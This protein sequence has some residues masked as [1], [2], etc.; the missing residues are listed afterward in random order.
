V[1]RAGP[2]DARAIL[3]CTRELQVRGGV[4]LE[5]QK[6]NANEGGN[7]IINYGPAFP[8]RSC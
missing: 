4:A 8:T 3:A 2:A 6:A 7:M 5:R 1:L